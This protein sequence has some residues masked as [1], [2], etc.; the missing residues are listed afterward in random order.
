MF[1]YVD[2]SGGI[3]I[4][5]NVRVGQFVCFYTSNHVFDD[6]KRPICAQGLNSRPIIIEDD[7][8]IG[9]HAV[10]LAG[11]II[12]HG[13]IVAAGAIVSHDVPAFSIVAGVPAKVIK[14]RR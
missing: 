12:H 8:W 9:A 5:K 1:N 6:P 13:S 14:N 11:C 2:G 4:G 7:V 10:I 3:K